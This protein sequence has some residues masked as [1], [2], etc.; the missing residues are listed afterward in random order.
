MI[1]K[2]YYMYELHEGEKELFKYI[3]PWRKDIQR[4]T[5][6]YNHNHYN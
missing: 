2:P 5:Y 1:C 4:D 6:V 3:P